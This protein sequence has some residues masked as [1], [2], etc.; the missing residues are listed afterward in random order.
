MVDVACGSIYVLLC[1]P[2]WDVT[3]I[4][5]PGDVWWAASDIG[6]TVGHGYIC[7]SPLLNCN[8]TVMYEGKPIGTPDAGQ[9]FRYV[10]ITRVQNPTKSLFLG[11][12][13]LPP[14]QGGIMQPRNSL[15]VGLCTSFRREQ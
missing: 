15:L 2:T 8:T 7:Y 14:W 5:S 3:L 9:F 11:F 6:W 1:L 12:V 10:E 4:D 13:H